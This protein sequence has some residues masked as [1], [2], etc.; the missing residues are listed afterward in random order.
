MFQSGI[1]QNMQRDNHF[2]G[3]ER[4]HPSATPRLPLPCSLRR[5]LM[6]ILSTILMIHLIGLPA[7][8]GPGSKPNP[9]PDAASSQPAKPKNVLRSN[10]PTSTTAP[11]HDRVR[12]PSA[13]TKSTRSHILLSNSPFKHQ[14]I[15]KNVDSILNSVSRRRADRNY[16]IYGVNKHG[17]SGSYS[18]SHHKDSNLTSLKTERFAH[19]K[20][21][22][23]AQDWISR[24]NEHKIR[25]LKLNSHVSIDINHPEKNAI[26]FS[27]NQKSHVPNHKL[28]VAD[29]VGA[30]TLLNHEKTTGKKHIRSQ[31]QHDHI[32]NHS[33]NTR[34]NDVMNHNLHERMSNMIKNEENERSP[35][36][37]QPDQNRFDVTTYTLSSS[38]L[39]NKS[40][41]TS[42]Q[43]LSSDPST[44]NTEQA[45]HHTGFFISKNAGMSF[46]QPS[47]RTGNTE[48]LS[49]FDQQ[50]ESKT[51]HSNADPAGAPM[52]PTIG[53]LQKIN[54]QP[55]LT[56]L[57]RTGNGPS[58]A[59]QP[60]SIS[61][62]QPRSENGTHEFSEMALPHPISSS[63][64]SAHK[65]ELTSGR[66][67]NNAPVRYVMARGPPR[68]PPSIT[69]YTYI[70]HETPTL[71]HRSQKWQLSPHCL[72]VTF[73]CCCS[74]PLFYPLRISFP[75]FHPSLT[76]IAPF[77]HATLP[78]RKNSLI[79]SSRHQAEF[80]PSP[81][82]SLLINFTLSNLRQRGACD[83]HLIVTNWPIRGQRSDLL[84]QTSRRPLTQPP[85]YLFNIRFKVQITQL[86]G[87]Y[88]MKKFHG[89]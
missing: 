3:D 18:V 20:G 49:N 10:T 80:P 69:K 71:S 43:L 57:K 8:S 41:T 88:I 64:Q 29:L 46:K 74:T 15:G 82:R 62:L 79:F 47:G 83:L 67:R 75:Y 32:M 37:I 36:N 33:R 56:S 23:S 51:L 59:Q 68:A 48:P 25:L 61:S 5:N 34:R 54:N 12:Q 38:Q 21:T 86:T 11:Q 53:K 39:T 50:P 87:R 28:V 73:S 6:Y 60:N 70:S 72:H 89:L 66:L 9:E 1:C 63:I 78:V 84:F 77:L 42:G 19:F 52:K 35:L 45:H 24:S 31:K 44:V 65:K 7:L 58:K 55:H 76:R 85:K 4:E 40:L 13:S 17:E 14:Y 22:V 81:L 30:A 27:K 16:N 26:P 2:G